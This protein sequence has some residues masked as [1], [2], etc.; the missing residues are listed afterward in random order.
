MTQEEEAEARSTAMPGGAKETI[1]TNIDGRRPIP[2]PA[3]SEEL[4]LEPK[5]A[6]NM[7]KLSRFLHP[8]KDTNIVVELYQDPK[9]DQEKTQRAS[10]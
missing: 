10:T 5:I 3:T 6:A 8:R 7:K 9:G 2:T 4:K 1:Y